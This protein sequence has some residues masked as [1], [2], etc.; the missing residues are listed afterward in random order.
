MANGFSP[1]GNHLGA[2]LSFT[3]F[4]FIVSRADDDAAG[5]RLKG[6]GGLMSRGFFNDFDADGA[7]ET[8]PHETIQFLVSDG[9]TFDDPWPALGARLAMPLSRRLTEAR[10]AVQVS[11]KYRPRL[12]EVE[13]ELRRRL[14]TAAEVIA[15]DG[16]ERTPRY[17]SSEMYDYAYRRAAARASGRLAR[18]A[19]VLP[20]S[21]NADWWQKPALERHAY[22]YPHIDSST[23]CHVNGHARTA[24][25]GIG[26]IFRRL[27]HNPDGYA[28]PGEYDFINYF[29]CDDANVDTFER[30]HHALRDT[31]KNPEW[32]YVQEGPLWRGRR[33][34][35]W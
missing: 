17:T 30:I 16:A 20:V 35:K 4:L 23:A 32:R 33:V 26:T 11:G 12:Q 3:K 14:G 10:Y 13:A 28:R 9:D 25:A 29:E 2:N 6:I 27:F 18:N 1:S 34:L 24:E 8:Q 21:K 22:F 31:T 5:T 7:R 19:F 15:L